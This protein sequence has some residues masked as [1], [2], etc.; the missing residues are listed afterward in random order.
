MLEI[1]SRRNRDFP[2]SSRSRHNPNPSFVQPPAH[3][4]LLSF[5]SAIFCALIDACTVSQGKY[6]ST[7]KG[8]SL[9][10]NCSTL[11]KQKLQNTFFLQLH[12]LQ[13]AVDLIEV[14][15][16]GAFTKVK[17]RGDCVAR[18]VCSNT[19]QCHAA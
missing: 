17:R 6:P 7:R 9:K 14:G 8:R 2:A 15:S 11:R 13:N 3:P 10:C 5:I 19:L 16:S 12:F 1:L 4:P 18:V